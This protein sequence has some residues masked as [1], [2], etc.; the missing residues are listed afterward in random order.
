MASEAQRIRQ[1]L[2][3]FS[4]KKKE[5]KIKTR[6]FLSLISSKR[7]T[8]QTLKNI[9]IALKLRG[10]TKSK[11]DNIPLSHSLKQRLLRVSE[12]MVS[13]TYDEPMNRSSI[14]AEEKLF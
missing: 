14:M 7:K 2:F 5:G 9:H 6:H 1:V 10:L 3:R 4:G 8:E 13:V 11:E 12:T